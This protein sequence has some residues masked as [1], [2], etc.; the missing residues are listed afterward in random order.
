[1]MAT[2][3]GWV[4]AGIGILV[5]LTMAAAGILTAGSG[6]PARPDRH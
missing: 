5:L 3:V 4:A 2:I 1:M 6:R